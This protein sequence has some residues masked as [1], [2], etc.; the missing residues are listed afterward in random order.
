MSFNFSRKKMAEHSIYKG[1]TSTDF[2]QK[3][4]SV[5]KDKAFNSR[6][7]R[8][9][10]GFYESYRSVASAHG[11]EEHHYTYLFLDYLD[12]IL[13]YLQSPFEFSPFHRQVRTPFDNFR[14]GIE[15]IKP[16]VNATDSKIFGLNNLEHVCEAIH[17]GENVILLANHQTEADP[18]AISLMLRD[19]KPKL[20]QDM[21]YVAGERVL[22][23]PLSVPFS[24]GCNLLC[25]YSKRYIDNPPNLR[26][27]KQLHNKKTMQLLSELLSE[28]GHCIYVAPSGGRDRKDSSG[29]LVPAEF[30]PQSIEMLY[31]MAK[32]AKKKTSF[33]PLSLYTYSILPPPESIQLELGEVRKTEGG[34]IR[35]FF[36]SPIDVDSFQKQYSDDKLLRRK[37]RAEH[38]YSLVLENYQKMLSSNS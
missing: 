33:L 35:L 1:S 22:T 12:Q 8:L 19:K 9:V 10:E 28:G 24:L 20:S 38:I 11:H 25:I 16:L 31:L 37:K 15:F 30:D 14:F 26:E 3:L 13:D 21:I 32:K 5:A 2:F 34:P 17:K 36:G 23:D 4:E 6:L 27:K 18:M 29:Q 7:K